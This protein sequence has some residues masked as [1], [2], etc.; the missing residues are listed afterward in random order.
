MKK[1]IVEKYRII[2]NFVKVDISLVIGEKLVLLDSTNN[3]RN[4][5]YIKRFSK[6]RIVEIIKST[7]LCIIESPEMRFYSGRNSIVQ[8]IYISDKDLIEVLDTK[9]DMI[10]KDKEEG[11]ITTDNMYGK[12]CKTIKNILITNN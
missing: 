11:Y 12:N 10:H 3:L 7:P 6:S 8:E 9:L 5:S 1:L 4:T 2:K